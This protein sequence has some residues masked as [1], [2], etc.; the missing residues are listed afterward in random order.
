MRRLKRML[1][2]RDYLTLAAVIAIL[3]YV[4]FVFFHYSSVGFDPKIMIYY[5]AVGLT[6]LLFIEIK[7]GRARRTIRRLSR[8]GTLEEALRDLNGG[9]VHRIPYIPESSLQIAENVLGR[10]FIFFF[11]SGRIIRYTQISSVSVYT[12]KEKTE[13]YITDTT[14]KTSSLFDLPVCRK[15]DIEEALRQLMERYPDCPRP[16]S[17]DLPLLVL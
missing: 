17:V 16:Q 9:D 4:V 12:E 1:K 8:D 10:E 5:P 13:L 7:A 2:G 14:G 15:R 3:A 11:S 6:I